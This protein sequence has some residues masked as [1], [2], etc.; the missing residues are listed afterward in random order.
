MEV[1]EERN[2]VQQKAPLYFFRFY[3]VVLSNA[4]HMDKT[5]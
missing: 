3:Y 4:H 5:F 2:V 1:Y